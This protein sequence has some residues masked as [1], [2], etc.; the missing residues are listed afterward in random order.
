ML[1]LVGGGENREKATKQQNNN[2]NLRLR[3]KEGGVA[4]DLS[5]YLERGRRGV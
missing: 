3:A 2:S 1:A 5:V 4:N